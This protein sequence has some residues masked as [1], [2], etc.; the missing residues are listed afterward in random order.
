[1]DIHSQVLGG[2]VTILKLEGKLNMVSAPRLREE[3]HSAV[4]AGNIQVANLNRMSG[5]AVHGRAHGAQVRVCHSWPD[6]DQG[7]LRAVRLRL[8]RR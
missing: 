8:L 7:P 1:M 4:V 5:H 3:V 2:G 6:V